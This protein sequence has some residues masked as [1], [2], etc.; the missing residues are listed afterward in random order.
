MKKGRNYF[1]FIIILAGIIV[2]ITGIDFGLPFLYHN[3]EPLVVHYAL[4]YSTGDFNP[5]FFKVPPLLS[6]MLFFMYGIFY[7]LGRAVGVFSNVKDFGFLFLN[8]PTLFYLIGRLMVGA[9]FG[10][11]SIYLIY[12]LAKR[13]FSKTV[14]LFSA[15]FLAFNFLHVRNS[16]YI[17]FDIPLVFCVILFFILLHRLYENNR[18]RDYVYTGLLLGVS[19][20]VKYNA[21]LLIVP[22][23]LIILRNKITGK[24]RLLEFFKKNIVLT[25]LVLTGLFLTNPFMFLDHR[26]FLE[27]ISKMPFSGVDPLFHLKISLLESCG[28]LLCIAAFFGMAFLVVKRNFFAIALSVFSI[29]YYITVVMVSQPAERYIFPLIPSVIVFSA[30]FMD[31]LLS[32]VKQL[33]LRLVCAVFLC[34]ILM[35]PSAGKIYLSNKL[36]LSED[37]RTAAYNWIEKNIPANSRIALDATGPIH[38]VLK[39]S[40]EQIRESYERLASGKFKKPRGALNYKITLQLENPDHP[41][42]TYRLYYLKKKILGKRFLH[43]YPG[44]EL[45]VAKLKQSNIEYVVVNRILTADSAKPFLKEL[46]KNSNVIAEFNP[47]KDGVEKIASMDITGV[48]AAAFLSEELKRRKSYGPVLR[49]YKL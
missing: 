33:N 48:P 34:L 49:I 28:L 15:L 19:I 14:G 23:F 38:P 37:T 27:N 5:H 9:L 4:A 11:A 41:D 45:D 46:E 44:I 43:A 40:K 39:K 13:V 17:Y 29:A 6:Y 10:S 1:L 31:L 35:A 47:Y 3:D 7:C 2:R 18:L 12:I 20:S 24:D 36:F 30:Y 8:N 21:A 22:L 16:H 26:S 42:T 25:A 32:K